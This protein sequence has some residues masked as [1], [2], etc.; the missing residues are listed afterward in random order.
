MLD[1]RRHIQSRPC[2]SIPSD[3][4]FPCVLANYREIIGVNML[5][6]G[7]LYCGSSEGSCV[8]GCQ[9]STSYAHFDGRNWNWF[10]CPQ[11][12]LGLSRSAALCEERRPH[13]EAEGHDRD[14]GKSKHEFVKVTTKI[15]NFLSFFFLSFL[16][17]YFK[18]TS[19]ITTHLWT[20]GRHLWLRA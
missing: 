12:R 20:K 13:N 8:V 1:K 9:T 10:S 18:E 17:F 19:T 14:Q 3:S 5:R 11:G 6:V 15:G 16:F 2:S 7:C 4:N